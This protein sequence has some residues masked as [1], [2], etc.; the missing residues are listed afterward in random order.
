MANLNRRVFLSEV[1]NTSR[2]ISASQIQESIV[3]RTTNSP[4]FVKFENLPIRD[5]I[6]KRIAFVSGLQNPVFTDGVSGNAM[7]MRPRSE[8]EIPVSIRNKTE[9]TLSFWLRPAW[10]QPTLNLEGSQDFSFY[11][12]PLINFSNISLNASSDFYE[13][14]GGFSIFEESIEGNRNQLYVMLDSGQTG[15]QIVLRATTPYDAGNFHHIY[16]SYKGASGLVN[17]F[18]DG[19]R[20]DFKTVTGSSIPAFLGFETIPT[21]SLEINSKAPGFSGLVRQNFGTID[22]LYFVDQYDG[23]SESVARHINFG[24]EYVAL[25]GLSKQDQSVAMFAFDDPTSLSLTSVLGNGTN[26]YAGRSDG[27]V[28]RGDR[29]LWRSRRDFSNQE[30]LNFISKKLLTEEAEVSIEDGALKIDKG[31]VRL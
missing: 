13:A 14:S 18:I 26:I 29:L 23:S 28:Y 10:L 21:V 19:K 11:R 8:V 31:S 5:E 20:S 3:R 12:M 27:R 9:F 1:E 16:I 2:S 30:E 17:I 24:T 25:G 7:Q 22:E 6:N 4:L 15:E